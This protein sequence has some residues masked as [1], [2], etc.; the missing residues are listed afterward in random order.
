MKLQMIGCNHRQAAVEFREQLSFT[1]AQAQTALNDFRN[2]FP[3]AEIVLLSTCNRV[4]LYTGA[5]DG[6]G[7]DQRA[8]ADFLAT[9][10]NLPTDGLLEQLVYLDG[11]AAI[12]HLFTVAAS[13]DSMV[14]GEAQIIS[15][16]KQAYE[17]AC[18]SGS[19]GPLT[20]AAFQAASHVAKRVDRETS[21]HRRR[22]SVPSVA[23]GEVIPEFFDTLADKC[24]VLIGAGEMGEE[25]LKYLVTAGAKDIHVVN[26]S[27]ERAE[28]IA[29]EIGGT[30]RPWPELD[31]LLTHADLIV[32]TTGATDTLITLE[33]FQTIHEAR[34]DRLL[35]ILDLAVPRD[36]AHD[37]G[38][39][40]SVYL[41]SVDDLQSAC[42]RNQRERQKQWPKAQGIIAE[43]SRKF[44]ADLHHRATGPVIR[45]LRDQ[46]EQLK[47][48]EL[49]RLMGRL[50][51]QTELGTQATKDIEQAFD[52]LVNK[53]LHPPLASLKD[54]AAAGHSGGLLVALRELFK[55]ND[56]E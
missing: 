3:A 36:F 18:E 40:A 28:K 48:E 42:E 1:T 51:Q 52:R 9:Q 22:V 13:L 23:V 26:R 33:R 35:L 56:G 41:Y 55:L 7:P 21:I 43:E 24:I 20:H 5:A 6:D 14:V 47:Q 31:L 45:Q 53:L 11:Q 39:L 16:V 25:T 8:M 12:E 34:Y 50:S 44:I 54:D 37:I 29:K 38:E 19:A 4:E 17:L 46:A 32:S 49:K 2:R 15:Q 27:R 30:A 10:R